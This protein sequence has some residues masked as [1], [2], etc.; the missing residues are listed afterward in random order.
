MTWRFPHA[1]LQIFARAPV[2]GEAKTRL[3]PLLG[4]AGAAELQARLLRR[5]VE[6]ALAAFLA[7]VQLWCTPDCDHPAFRAWPEVSRHLQQGGEL[8]ERM[9]HALSS[10]L[11]R[12]ERVV[13]IGTDCPGLD[14]AYLQRALEFL[15]D[16]DVVLGPA[17]DGGY[18]LIGC[19]RPVEI[20]HRIDWGTD[21]VLL[22]TRERLREAGIG[23]REL[24]LRWDVDRPP[25]LQR[26]VAGGYLETYKAVE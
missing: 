18:V 16:H 6:T 26:M 12:A 24:P 23:W 3:I 4:A 21:R 20:F 14:A 2:P 11:R 25:D 15:A 22:Q 5:T 9:A 8:G 7:P 1:A 10:G 19:R 17:E 13:L